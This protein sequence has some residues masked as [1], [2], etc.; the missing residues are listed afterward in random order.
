MKTTYFGRSVGY[1]LLAGG[2][3]ALLFGLGTDNEPLFA[4]LTR[5]WQ[6]FFANIGLGP[7]LRALQQGT[8]AEVARRSLPALLSYAGLY[9]ALSLALLRV[10]VPGAGQWWLAVRLYAA[11]ALLCA[12]LVLAGQLGGNVVALYRGARH[13]IEFLVSP[14]PVILLA[15]LL[16]SPLGRVQEQEQ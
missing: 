9:L 5:T 6:A 7:W 1:W 2:L 8:N 15:V 3:V 12:A 4:W 10:L 16:N 11:G 13:L 14:L